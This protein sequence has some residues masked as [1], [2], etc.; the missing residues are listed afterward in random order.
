[1]RIDG[2][3]FATNARA[4][5][6]E[7]EA[8]EVA[9][10]VADIA[11]Q[12]EEEQRRQLESLLMKYKD[13]L[14]KELEDRE[15]VKGVEH[16]IE[17]EPGTKP[18]CIP[19]RR[20]SP[21]EMEALTKQVKELKEKKVIR[22]SNSPWCA[23]ALLVPK[24]DGSTRMTIDY[25]A[26]NKHTI[27]DRFPLPNINTIFQHLGGA[28]YFSTFDLASGYYQF[29]MRECD[30][31]KTAFATPEGLYEFVHMPMGLSN[32]PA[33]FQRAMTNIF[34][35]MVYHGVMVFID[36]ILVYSKTWKE[37]MEKLEEVLR[38][39]KENNLQAKVAKCHFAQPQTQYLGY[40]ITANAKRP[41][42]AKVKAIQQMRAPKDKAEVR[43]VL[44]LAGFYRDFIKDFGAL[45]QPLN[46]LLSKDAVFT[47]GEQQETAFN[48]L[49]QA[50]SEK[51]LLE[52]PRPEW[53]YEVHTDASTVA[54]G[55]VL[56][57]RDPQGKPHIIEYMSKV[58]AKPQRKLSIPVL[59]CMAIVLAL[60]KFR[61]FVYGT[62][63][64]IFSDHYG[65]QFLKS[66]QTPS[67]QMQR[68]WWE[69]SE[70]DCDVVYRK[71]EI[72]IADPLSRLVSREELE[73]AQMTEI[74][75]LDLRVCNGELADEFEVEK[76]IGK[77]FDANNKVEYLVKWK[78]YGL[79]E[80]TW[81][82]RKNMHCPKLVRAYEAQ[83]RR[84]QQAAEA[85]LQTK[86][87]A[88]LD[89]TK[90]AQAQR[91]DDWCK[92][93]RRCMANKSGNKGD[94]KN[95][96]DDVFVK[97]EAQ[98]CKERDG[99]L[100]RVQKGKELLV[101]PKVQRGC[102]LDELHSSLFGGHLGVERTLTRIT[103]NYWWPGVKQD[104][105]EYIRTCPACN[106]RNHGQRHEAPPLAPEPRIS[107]P[108]ERIGIDFMEE[109]QSARGNHA[110]LVVIDHATK[111]VE[112]KACS[113]ETAE[114][115]A[116]FVFENIICRHGA[117]KEIWSDRGKCF[118]GEVM[119]HLSKLCGIEQRFTSGYHPQTNGLTERMN[120]TINEM[121]AKAV[122]DNQRNWDELLPAL[123]WSYN[124]SKHSATGYS[125]F[126][127][128]HGHAPVLPLDA[129]LQDD[130]V[131]LRA[132]EW[133]RTLGEQ[134]K[135]LQN[136]NLANQKKA[137]AAQAAQ[138]NKDKKRAAQIKVGDL[139]HWRRPRI[140][141]EL[142]RKLVSIWRGPFT[143]TEKLGDVNYRLM[144][145]HGV[146]AD[147][148]AHAGDL[149]VVNGERP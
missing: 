115:A 125:P 26:L 54:V 15:A 13:V 14:V 85:K 87:M 97:K 43:S 119:A 80:A 126:E 58:L 140:G 121:L 116:R 21:K 79:R 36:D 132:S 63:F 113:D 19:V 17:L 72:N 55:A 39:M 32:A 53:P 149:M 93:V 73:R 7:G 28:K 120:R 88:T 4:R 62:H 130:S 123:V 1:M 141:P 60:R 94:Q 129:K 12:L 106:A 148:P 108:F 30:I 68:W 146:I 127:L 66:K 40:V 20:F 46:D 48:M 142:N 76:I 33:T 138:Y 44:G 109:P 38:R 101:I 22:P 78:G 23:R 47:W 135:M 102:I 117:P 18:I 139:V 49:K 147:T 25:T 65:L 99:L 145:K 144:D 118:T 133:V 98:L 103:Q 2:E 81:E 86:L 52:F 61:D 107:R 64:T 9:A 74:D 89:R 5:K 45:T 69:T 70:Y 77:R 67:P 90:V 95:D 71:G 10:V 42:P 29:K 137:A 136:A 57:Q 83:W 37:H 59:E 27:K 11:P 82:P 31:E 100:Y 91:D 131:P 6:R 41:D 143:V 111:W 105:K 16:E 84:E 8:N 96:D 124:T 92:R 34:A 75:A 50:I 122:A 134:V 24:K 114:T 112:A 51:S 56:L 128:N 110:V 35:N 104:V 3:T